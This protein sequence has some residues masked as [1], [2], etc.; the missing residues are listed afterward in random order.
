[1][2]TILG[3]LLRLIVTL[4]ILAALGYNTWQIA[5][6]RAEVETL[7]RERASAVKNGKEDGKSHLA[8][9]R[10]HAE[11]AQAF[12]R[13]KQYADAQREIRAATEA[14]RQASSDARAGSEDRLTQLRGALKSLTDQTEA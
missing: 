10:R 12:L 5:A 11:Q 4:F 9:A 8:R 7:K 3:G 6:L 13:K 14:L 1:M 2:G